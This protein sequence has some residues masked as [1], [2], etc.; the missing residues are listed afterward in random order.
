LCDGFSLSETIW[1]KKGENTTSLCV[2]LSCGGCAVTGV[3]GIADATGLTGVAGEL[4]SVE[5]ITLDI[6]DILLD[7]LLVTALILHRSI[8]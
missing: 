8:L 4:I 2:V 6:V 1:F 7:K 3:A 5:G